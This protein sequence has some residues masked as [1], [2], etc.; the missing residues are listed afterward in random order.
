MGVISLVEHIVLLHQYSHLY[1]TVGYTSGLTGKPMITGGNT[2]S[3]KCIIKWIVFFFFDIKQCM[4]SVVVV[5]LYQSEEQSQIIWKLE[6]VQLIPLHSDTFY[7]KVL[8][9]KTYLKAGGISKI[10]CHY[11]TNSV[12]LGDPGI[13]YI[14]PNHKLLMAKH[15]EWYGILC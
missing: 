12:L 13:K 8:L 2:G 7:I 11:F 6:V 15:N 4:L 9:Y 10:Q 1:Y 5:R 3:I 14:F